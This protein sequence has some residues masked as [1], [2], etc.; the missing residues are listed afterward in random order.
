MET[1]ME[2][3]LFAAGLLLAAAATQTL[4]RLARGVREEGW[5]AT[6]V[7]GMWAWGVIVSAIVSAGVWLHVLIGLA[8]LAAGVAWGWWSVGWAHPS[9]ERKA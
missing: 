2:V 3:L 9:V 5:A 7:A 4:F 6:L 1:A 8:A